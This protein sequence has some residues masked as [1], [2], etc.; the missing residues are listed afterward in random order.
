VE[1]TI[2]VGMS[3]GPDRELFW[4]G[5]PA[6][7]LSIRRHNSVGILIADR[8]HGNTQKRLAYTSR[9]RIR[10]GRPNGGQ[11]LPSPNLPLLSSR[12]TRLS[13]SL[14][15][16]RMNRTRTSRFS[17]G[18]TINCNG[19]YPTEGVDVALPVD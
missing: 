2:S 12:E 7:F 5:R 10:T 9:I 6:E 4:L 11:V 16:G 14:T 17:R 13:T 1:A 3:Q 15:H 19:K 8:P 18:T